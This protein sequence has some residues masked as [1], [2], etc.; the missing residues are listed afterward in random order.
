MALADLQ[1]RA[2]AGD[3]PAQIGLADRLDAQGRHEEAIDWLSRAAGSGDAGALAR[4]GFRLLEGLNAPAMPR[5]GA[6]LLSDAAAR[7]DAEAAAMISVLAGGG[8]HG[9]QSW[10][11][12]LDYLQRSA[13][14]GGGPARIQLR[15]LAADPALQAQA[16]AP[17]PAPDLWRRLRQG[18]ELDRWLAPPPSAQLHP[19][20]R[21]SVLADLATPE[22]CDWIVEQSRPRLERALVH[23]PETGQTIMGQT[24]TNRVASFGLR[25]TNLLYLLIQARIAAAA[26]TAMEMM[27]AFA[28]LHYAV[29]EEASEHFDALDPAIPA[30]AEA[31]AR[32]GQ[33]VA[34]CLLYLND[35]YEGGDTEF[36]V[37]GLRHCGRRGQGLLFESVDALGAPDPRSLHAGRPPRSGEKW[38]LSQFIRNRP[39]APGRPPA[40]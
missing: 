21:I 13:E 3:V 28:V 40:R 33:R 34:T 24:R 11:V 39:L 36:P 9:P 5:E 4:L 35:G 7:G 17:A 15:L 27:E 6:G 26:G 30:S 20:P 37:L 14:L 18:V 38:V 22:I 12:A 25:E 31:I 19:A 8:F 1:D 23:D 32:Y 29:G 10:S 2:Q 16:Q